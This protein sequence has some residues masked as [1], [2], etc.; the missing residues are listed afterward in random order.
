MRG[1]E[2]GLPRA[3]ERHFGF[4]A[5]SLGEGGIRTHTRQELGALGR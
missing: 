3:R 1:V 5:V 2:E 4:F